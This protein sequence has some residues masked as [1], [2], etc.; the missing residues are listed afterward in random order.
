[1]TYYD[2]AAEVLADL[3]GRPSEDF[4]ASGYDIPDFKDQDLEVPDE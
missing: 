2:S 4:D 3:T 1:V